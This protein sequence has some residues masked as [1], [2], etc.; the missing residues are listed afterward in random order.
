MF[1]TKSYTPLFTPWTPSLPT[2][3]ENVNMKTAFSTLSIHQNRERGAGAAWKRAV[4]GRKRQNFM[5]GKR[6]RCSEID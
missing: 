2:A 4:I 6:R 3:Y 5:R 1:C